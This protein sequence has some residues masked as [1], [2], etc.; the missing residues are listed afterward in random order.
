M[1]KKIII[2]DLPVKDN[3]KR[4]LLISKTPVWWKLGKYFINQEN[5]R[6]LKRRGKTTAISFF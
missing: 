3:N 1:A 5:I 6:A 4:S 2:L